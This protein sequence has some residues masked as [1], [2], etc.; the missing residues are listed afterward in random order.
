MDWMDTAR[1]QQVLSFQR[2]SSSD[3]YAE[4]RARMGWKSRPLRAVAPVMA[5]LMRRKSPYYK[6]ARSIRRPVG[7]DPGQVG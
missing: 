7:Q 4:I 3:T 5:G 2:H 6:D 1:A